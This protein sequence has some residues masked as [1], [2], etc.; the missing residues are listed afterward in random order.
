MTDELIKRLI[1]TIDGTQAFVLDQVPDVAR[2]ALL[3]A[4]VEKPLDLLICLGVLFGVWKLFKLTEHKVS[5]CNWDGGAWILVSIGGGLAAIYGFCYG[6]CS[7][8]ESI[9][10]WATPKLYLLEYLSH[11]AKQA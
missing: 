6:V 4:R 10:V 3:F 8:Q 5:E 1:M 9:K 2:Q 7:L 11:L